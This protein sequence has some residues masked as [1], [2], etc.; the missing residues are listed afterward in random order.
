[1]TKVTTKFKS[2]LLVLQE[3]V[4]GIYDLRYN[5]KVYRKVYKYYKDQGVNF[6]GDSAA[7]YDV[8]L[9]LLYEEGIK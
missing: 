8:I 6:I 5:Q 9:D 1:M 2:H 4:R 7:D 3:A